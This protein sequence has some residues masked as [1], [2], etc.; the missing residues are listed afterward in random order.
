MTPLG[1]AKLPR[2]SAGQQPISLRRSPRRR[3]RHPSTRLGTWKSCGRYSRSSLSPHRNELGT[4][5]NSSRRC[6]DI[7]VE[8]CI[9]KAGGMTDFATKTQ[10]LGTC[11]SGNIPNR[12][13]TLFLIVRIRSAEQHH[14]CQVSHCQR[15][16]IRPNALN[17]KAVLFS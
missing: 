7:F 13:M 2:N 1:T 5:L 6:I 15:V 10:R 14:Q 4:P 16:S 11:H 12:F 17:A 8:V 9:T 3:H